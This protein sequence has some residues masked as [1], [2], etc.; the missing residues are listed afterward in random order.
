MVIRSFTIQLSILKDELPRS[1]PNPAKGEKQRLRIREERDAPR[2]PRSATFYTY[3][4]TTLINL[5]EY[6][7]AGSEFAVKR[8]FRDVVALSKQL[9]EAYRGFFIPE[10]LDKSMMESQV[11]QKQEFV[12]QRR[13]AL[14]KYLR[15]LAAHSVI[16]RSEELR[17][18]LEAK[19]RLPLAKTT[20]V[21]SRM[22]DGTVR[23]PRQLFSGEAEL[24]EMAQL[25]K[26]RRDLLKIF[27]ELK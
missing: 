9:A 23:L 26:G 15:K 8:R 11:M 7:G 13:V 4:I 10:R 2:P 1:I 20:Y 17:L 12:G 25:A 14:E 6:G 21:A 16:G 24:G 3:L 22:L 27:K 19:G 5:L 18:F